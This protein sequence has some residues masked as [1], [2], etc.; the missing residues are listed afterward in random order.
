MGFTL[1][2]KRSAKKKK[3]EK[4]EGAHGIP[5][6]R[7]EARGVANA[8]RECIAMHASARSRVNWFC[9]TLDRPICDEEEIPS[10]ASPH[11]RAADI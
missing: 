3:R 9:I 10:S 2:A 1:P 8:S 4:H 11:A 7:I 6:E 5:I